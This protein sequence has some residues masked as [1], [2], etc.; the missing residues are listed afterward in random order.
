MLQRIGG[1]SEPDALS[2]PDRILYATDLVTIGEFRAGIDHPRFH[3]S[4]PI[5]RPIFVFP[6]TSVVIRHV[7]EKPFLADPCT[8]TLYNEGQRYTRE[9]ADPRGDR[10]DWFS[11][12]HDVLMEVL[13]MFDPAVPDRPD[14]PFDRTY[15]HGDPEGYAAQRTILRY[16][17]A[18]GER[19]TLAV[20]EAVL[21]LLQRIAKALATHPAVSGANPRVSTGRASLAEAARVLILERFRESL[22]LGEVAEAVG[23][24]VFHLC[25]VFRGVMGMTIHTY[26]QQLRLRYALELVAE[27]G[28][29]LTAIALRLGFSSHSHF[30]EAFRS[31]FGITPSD[32][33]RRPSTKRV[34]ELEARLA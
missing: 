29:N 9:A 32:F 34:R 10:C 1:R 25:R 3:D 30:T 2:E 4:G 27:P 23:C 11:V 14:G 15:A 28:S 19:D 7:G 33:R 6:R 24:S 17:A 26:R 13:A 31:G 12:R 16:L 5:R 21:G 8:I 20:E 22:T 18:A